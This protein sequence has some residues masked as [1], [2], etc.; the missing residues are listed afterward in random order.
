[1]TCLTLY[2][3]MLIIEAISMLILESSKETTGIPKNFLMLKRLLPMFLGLDHQQNDHA[4]YDKNEEEN[5]LS[6][7]RPLLVA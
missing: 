7:G 5:N 1:M 2:W 6:F 4:K 3:Y